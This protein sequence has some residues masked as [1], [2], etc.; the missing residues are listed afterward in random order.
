MTSRGGEG[1]LPYT[2][3]R[4]LGTRF[5]TLRVGACIRRCVPFES[6]GLNWKSLRN[7]MKVF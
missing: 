7:G 2:H 3:L 5:M 6:R 1:F 4:V